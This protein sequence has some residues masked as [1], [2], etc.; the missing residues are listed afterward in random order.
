MGTT[1]SIVIAGAKDEKNIGTSKDSNEIW[2]AKKA[3][4]IQTNTENNTAIA[5]L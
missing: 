1:S 2:A 3:E 5:Y 4:Y